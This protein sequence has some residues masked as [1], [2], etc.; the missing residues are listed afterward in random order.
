MNFVQ[1]ATEQT[2]ASTDLI[3]GIISLLLAILLIKKSGVRINYWKWFYVFLGVAA[4]AGA[5][6]HGVIVSQFTKDMLWYVIYFSLGI[7]MAFI[8]LASL[9]INFILFFVAMGLGI[10]FFLFTIFVSKSFIVFVVYAV[11]IL[12]AVFG[13]HLYKYIKSKQFSWLVICIGILLII[14]SGGVQAIVKGELNFIWTFDHNGLA[15]I[16]QTIGAVVLYFGLVKSFNVLQ[17]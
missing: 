10:L 13:I 16:V 3:S 11:A 17:K 4:L 14:V 6:A 8:L 12:T 5:I 1:I 2:I 15:H 7:G 9:P